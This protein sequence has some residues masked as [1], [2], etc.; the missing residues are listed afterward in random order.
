MTKFVCQYCNAIYSTEVKKLTKKDL[1]YIK[2]LKEIVE[3]KYKEFL[4]KRKNPK[5][6]SVKFPNMEIEYLKTNNFEDW[7]FIVDR[8]IF[9]KKQMY[10]TIKD[11]THFHQCPICKMYKLLSL[12]LKE[13]KK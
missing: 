8:E 11:K 2:E 3:R 13:I 12:R 4:E 10:D 7:L 5:R 1:K 6:T 9:R